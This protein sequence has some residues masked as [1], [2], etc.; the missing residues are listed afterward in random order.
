M[1]LPEPPPKLHY[2]VAGTVA[3]FVFG[4][5]IL[6][7]SG[8]CTGIM[9]GGAILGML[10]EPR[11]A[12]DGVGM[13]AMALIVGGPFVVGGGALVWQAIRRMRGH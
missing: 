13:L 10:S 12:G 11:S 9:G 6:V 4:L 8:L 5:L 1:S 2:N 3:L 7:P